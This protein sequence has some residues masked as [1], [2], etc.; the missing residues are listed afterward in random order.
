MPLQE[1]VDLAGY[2]V[3]GLRA[4][5][6]HV[7]S[8][9]QPVELLTVDEARQR[10]SCGYDRHRVDHVRRALGLRVEVADRVDLVA[11]QLN[12]GGG[13]GGDGVYVDDPAAPADETGHVDG[14]LDAV[15]HP[16]PRVDHLFEVDPQAR[17]QGLDA[18]L[19]G[20]AADGLLRHSCRGRDDHGSRAILREGPQGADSVLGRVHIGDEPLEGQRLGLRE[21]Q[22]GRLV[23]GPEQH[24][25]IEAPGI[26]GTR[27]NYQDGRLED[28]VDLGEGEGGGLRQH[29]Q[30]GAEP[31]AAKRRR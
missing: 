4:A 22:D 5:S 11:P 19:Q 8:A 12:A 1:H 23:P 29:L 28:A 26:L 17:V 18:V 27:R 2:P 10:L 16:A 24:L 31:A 13:F 15:A 6:G 21:V 30:P 14:G 25:L 9:Q 20:L 7:D 3:A